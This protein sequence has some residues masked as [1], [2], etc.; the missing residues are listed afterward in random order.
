LDLG[1]ER[2]GKGGVGRSKRGPGGFCMVGGGGGRKRKEGK[3]GGRRGWEGWGRASWTGGSIMGR[4]RK[5]G[6]LRG[7]R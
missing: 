7:R 2:G 6:G 4:E 1:G 3:W 5:G